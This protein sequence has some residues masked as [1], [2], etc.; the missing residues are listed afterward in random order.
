M[1]SSHHGMMTYRFL[2]VPAQEQIRQ[3]VEL[4]RAEGWLLPGDDR[5][6]QLIPRLIAGSH[7]F[8][9]ATDGERIVGMGRAISDGISDAYIQ[10]LTVHVDYRNRGIGERILMLIL[11][12]LHVDGILWIGLIAVMESC[13][14]Y[15]RV[16]FKEMSMS[17]PM[18]M[19]KE[20]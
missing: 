17:V 19:I 10:D 16:G 3:I 18:L 14:L 2:K 5:R 13:N 6:D 4:Y 7:C 9:I 11:E 8:A 12:R 15:R 1:S 20:P